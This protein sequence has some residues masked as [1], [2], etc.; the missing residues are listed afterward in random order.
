VQPRIFTRH[1]CNCASFTA[2]S[3]PAA[4]AA[5]DYQFESSPQQS[6]QR[7]QQCMHVNPHVPPTRAAAA[8]SSSNV[9]S[10]VPGQAMLRH[11]MAFAAA[12]SAT[13]AAAAGFILVFACGGVCACDFLHTG[14]GCRSC[15]IVVVPHLHNHALSGKYFPRPSPL[16]STKSRDNTSDL[17]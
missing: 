17:W 11:R 7:Q 10:I 8:L 5:G 15:I 14:R 1:R 6:D 2:A 12:E 13:A 9:E 4:A 3:A 16:R